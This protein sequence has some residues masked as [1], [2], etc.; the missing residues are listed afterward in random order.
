MKVSSRRRQLSAFHGV[1]EVV[2]SVCDFLKNGDGVRD[3]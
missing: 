3:Q 2:G 1:C